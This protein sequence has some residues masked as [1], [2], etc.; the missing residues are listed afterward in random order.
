M[1]TDRVLLLETVKL[2]IVDGEDP[3]A[4]VPLEL[5]SPD[6][7]SSGPASEGCPWHADEVGNFGE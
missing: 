3:P 6:M 5:A 1:K 2:S 4:T 7:A